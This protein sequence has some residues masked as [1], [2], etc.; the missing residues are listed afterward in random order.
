MLN[1]NIVVALRPW[2]GLFAAVTVGDIQYTGVLAIGED[3]VLWVEGSTGGDIRLD[4][5]VDVTIDIDPG[6]TGFP[7]ASFAW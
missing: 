7:T 3:V 2:D 5:Q 4:D 6:E 1:T